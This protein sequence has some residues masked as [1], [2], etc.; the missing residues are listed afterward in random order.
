[1]NKSNSRLDF[2]LQL[3]ASTSSSLYMDRNN[4]YKDDI[5]IDDQ[6]FD[7]NNSNVLRY[8]LIG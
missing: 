8:E 4:E 6:D 1:M 3:V 7:S 5:S 2:K